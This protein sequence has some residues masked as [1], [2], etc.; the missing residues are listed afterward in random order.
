M[1]TG[2]PPK[3]RDVVKNKRELIAAKEDVESRFVIEP[4]VLD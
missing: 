3:S 2:K 1:K 4:V